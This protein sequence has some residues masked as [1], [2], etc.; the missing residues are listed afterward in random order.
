MDQCE[1]N[2]ARDAREAIVRK[3]RRLIAGVDS[4]YDERFIERWHEEQM[5]QRKNQRLKLPLAEDVNRNTD[6]EK[7]T[8]AAK[9]TDATEAAGSTAGEKIK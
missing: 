4:V 1:R 3:N 2:A 6:A 7:T 9:A 5:K 8:K